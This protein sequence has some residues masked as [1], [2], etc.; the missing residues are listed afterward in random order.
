MNNFKFQNPTKIV[1]GKGSIANISKLI[2]K[3]AKVLILYGGGSIKKNGVYDQVTSALKKHTTIEFGGIEA[4]PDYDTLK[5]AVKL[6]KTEKVDFL[7]AVGGGSV[8]DGTKFISVAAHYKGKHPWNLLAKHEANKIKKAVPIGVVLTLPATGSEMNMNA[9]ISRRKSEEKLSFSNPNVFPRFSILDPEVTYSLPEK[10]I[11]NGIV[12]AYVHVMEQYMTYPVGAIVQDR[13]AEAILHALIELAPKAL[14]T[15]P[16][17][18]GRANFMW[19]ATNALNHLISSG[20][21]GDWATHEIGHELTALY[22]LDHAETLAV[23]LPYI[24]WYKRDKKKR[25]LL[26]YGYRVLNTRSQNHEERISQTI[27]KTAAFFQGLGMP[28]TL[29]AYNIDPD[30]AAEKVQ[31]RLEN[32]GIILGEHNDITPEDVANIIRMSR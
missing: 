17:Y 14:E 11:R 26:Q 22:G 15:P 12:D 31:S 9:V 2:P 6:V 8:I 1:F 28:T 10:Y 27:E 16:D 18:L 30:E 3:H 24:L 32:R 19:A 29:T 21:P 4:N 23:I 25:K 5:R 7:L 20:V 13:Q